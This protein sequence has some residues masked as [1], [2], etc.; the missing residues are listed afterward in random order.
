MIKQEIKQIA[1]IAIPMIDRIIPAVAIVRPVAF[2]LPMTPRMVPTMP[3]HRPAIEPHNIH[4]KAATSTNDTIPKTKE[5]IARPLLPV[6][7]C[8]Y[9]GYCGSP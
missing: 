2:F 5:A 3:K 7:G 1:P 6:F 4:E 9:I 8:G